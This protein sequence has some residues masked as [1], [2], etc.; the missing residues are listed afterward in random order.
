MA[1]ARIFDLPETKGEFQLR[2][3]VTGTEKDG[4]YKEIRTKTNKEMRLINFGAEYERGKT[5]YVGLQGMERDN[6]Y[7]NKPAK[8]KG[9]KSDTVAVPWAERLSYNREGY[10]MIG[11]N[12]G[13]KKIVNAE[14]KTVNDKK[15]MTEF[16]ACREVGENLKDGA[17]V[18]VRGNLE[19]SSFIDNGG[20]KKVSVKLSPRQ[21]SLCSDVNLDENNFEPQNDFRQTIVFMGIDKEKDDN[22]KETGRF[23]VSA[24]IITY[25]TIEDMEFIIEDSKLAGMFRKNLK[26]YNAITVSGHMVTSRQVE[27]VQDDDEWGEA[28]AMDRVTAP[29]K[30][31]FIIT[32]AKGSTVDKELYTKENIEDAMAKIA[33]ANKVNDDFGTDSNDDW[34]DVGSNADDDDE[35]WD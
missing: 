34:G 27:E 18:F 4:F 17:S 7:F 23:V 24:K 20:N 12:I 13:V 30:R 33:Q 25:S 9:G 19:C 10:R 35:A 16:D 1:K 8:E 2:G 11:A 21:I 3:V 5:L 26:P 28:D 6:V 32:G 22:G 14:G 15:V 29:T 31:E